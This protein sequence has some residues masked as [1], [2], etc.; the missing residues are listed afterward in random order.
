[1]KQ[2]FYVLVEMSSGEAP[3]ELDNLEVFTNRDDAVKQMEKSYK[4][5]LRNLK[6]YGYIEDCDIDDEEY[7][8]EYSDDDCQTTYYG[9]YVRE[10]EAK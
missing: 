10:V 2:K 7:S 1:M 6:K 5:L 3:T 8:V 9:G 4:K